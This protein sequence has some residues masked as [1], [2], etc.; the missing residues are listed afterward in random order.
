MKCYKKIANFTSTFVIISF[1]VF[2]FPIYS[3]AV[4]LNTS[5]S[6]TIT[7]QAPSNLTATAASPSQINL[8]WTD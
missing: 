3:G 4:D 5:V 1:F 6:V 8:S 7:P 2:S